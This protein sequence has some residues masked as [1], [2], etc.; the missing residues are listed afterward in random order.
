MMQSTAGPWG[1]AF[2]GER[3]DQLSTVR[4]TVGQ[5]IVRFLAQQYVERDGEQNRFIAGVWGIFGHGNVAGLGQALEELG[6]EYEM[7]YYR[8]QNEQAQVHLAAAY[9]KHKNRMQTFACISSIGPGAT[10]MITGAATATRQPAAGPAVPVGLLRQPARGPGAP[11]GRA[12]RR[13]RRLGL[14]RLPSRLPL[15]RPHLPA[16]AAPLQPAG[17]VPRPHRPG[18]DRRRDDLPARGRPGRG[19]R[20]ARAVLRAARLA[21]PPA[22]PG[23]GARG[24]GG[25]PHP[26]RAAAPHRRGRRCD[27]RGCR[28]GPGR[29]GDHATGSRSASRRPARARCPGTT[30]RT[31]VRSGRR[32]ASRPTGWPGT[33]TS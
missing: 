29:P 5:A 9:A 24:R 13:A 4:L 12:P 23:G 18:R 8:P 26:L 31:S 25:R 7:P 19:L 1:P 3:S 2:G 21:G 27:L 14:G 11:A 30:R 28:G 32:A 22:A 17:G 10:N 20:L 16:R 15:L 6:D 33:P